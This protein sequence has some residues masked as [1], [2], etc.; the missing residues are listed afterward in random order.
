M[1]DRKEK[2]CHKSKLQFIQKIWAFKKSHFIIENTF[3][4]HN[5]KKTSKSLS[6]VITQ[7]KLI[8]YT[9]FQKAISSHKIKQT[10]LRTLKNLS[11]QTVK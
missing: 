1:P 10:T 4:E 6:E 11:F 3:Y 5:L 2:F 7:K 8:T 9:L